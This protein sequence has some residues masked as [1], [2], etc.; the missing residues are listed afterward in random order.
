[1]GE[2]L[3]SKYGQKLLDS[4]E[5]SAKDAPTTALNRAAEA[6]DDLLGSKIAKI[7]KKAASKSTCENP[8]NLPAQTHETSI[9]PLGIPKE[10]KTSPER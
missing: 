5:K 1:M 10:R 9:Q 3:S 8:E 4:T 6:T 7:T 2:C